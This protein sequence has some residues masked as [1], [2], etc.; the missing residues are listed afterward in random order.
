MA[1]T[2]QKKWTDAMEGEMESLHVNEVWDLMELPKDRKAIGSKWVFKVNR[3]ANG[4]VE[5]H[6]ACLVAQGYSQKYG[7]DY[8]E[9]F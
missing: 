7:Q 2:D 1:S 9:T 3:S 6:K 4:V 8:D 5:R